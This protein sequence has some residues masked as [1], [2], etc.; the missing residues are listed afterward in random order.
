MR[1]KSC[2]FAE[3]TWHHDRVSSVSVYTTGTDWGAI[4]AAVATAVAAIAGIWG[5][6][7]QARIARQSASADLKKSI[8]AAAENIRI[9]SEVED[10]RA[11]LAEKRQAYAACQAAFTAVIYAV[12]FRSPLLTDAQNRMLTAVGE[13]RLVA[14][15]EIGMAAVDL[16]LRIS[17]YAAV[18]SRTP[19]TQTD[20]PWLQDRLYEAMRDD[21][22]LDD[23]TGDA[24]A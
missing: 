3:R 16:Q 2:T 8:D 7:R 4:A 22:N 1:E 14:P 6:S 17:A 19:E 12:Q 11:R 13:L 20:Y 18:E 24:E 5:T 15:P 9:A 23:H 21:L 10:R